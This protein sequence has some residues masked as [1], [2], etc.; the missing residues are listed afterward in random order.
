MKSL[1]GS[2]F[3]CGTTPKGEGKTITISQKLLC[4]ACIIQPRE[5]IYQRSFYGQAIKSARGMPWHQEP[6]KD[7]TSCDKPRGG[8]NIHRSG[9]FRMGKPTRAILW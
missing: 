1:E 8:A 2:M 5:L 7:V 9:D 6:M 4:E 3:N